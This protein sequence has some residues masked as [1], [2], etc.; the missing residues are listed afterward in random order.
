MAGLLWYLDIARYL[1]KYGGQVDWEKLIRQ[2]KLSQ[3]SA[4]V[5]YTLV[6]LQEKFGTTLPEGVLEKLKE[7]MTPQEDRQIQSKM[8]PIYGSAAQALMGFQNLT[9]QGKVKDIFSRLFPS[10]EFLRERFGIQKDWMLIVGYPLRW[11]ELIQKGWEY[12]W[13]QIHRGLI[14]RE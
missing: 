3:W 7:N 2:A 8:T 1:A 13:Q 11:V 14:N 6:A 12:L 4:A 5:Y 10:L 9:W